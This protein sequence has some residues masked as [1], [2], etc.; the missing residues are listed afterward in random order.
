VTGTSSEWWKRNPEKHLIVSNIGGWRWGNYN[1]LRDAHVF[2][3][4][5][6]LPRYLRSAYVTSRVVVVPY[7]SENPPFVPIRDINGNYSI[8]LT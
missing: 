7:P 5:L 8:P 6:E 2:H 3:V 4:T 1:F